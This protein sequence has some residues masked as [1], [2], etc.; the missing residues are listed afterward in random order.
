M[1]LPVAPSTSEIEVHD[2]VP[3]PHGRCERS[4]VWGLDDDTLLVLAGAVD[5][6]VL[7]DLE[8]HP[9]HTGRVITRCRAA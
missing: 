2:R 9:Q 5:T 7:D 3:A 1:A 4:R 8:P 6:A